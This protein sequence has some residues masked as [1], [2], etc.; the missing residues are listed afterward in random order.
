MT[1][2]LLVVAGAALLLTVA[3]SPRTRASDA[4]A[5]VAAA[6]ARIRTDDVQDLLYLGE[7]RPLRIRLHVRIDGKPFRQVWN[8]FLAR[9]FAEADVNGDKVLSKEEANRLPEARLLLNLVQGQGFFFGGP[10]GSST[11]PFAQLDANKDGKVTLEEVKAYYRKSGF[12]PLQTQPDPDQGTT[13]LLTDALFKHLDRDGDGKLSEKELK[14]AE[15]TLRPLDINEDERISFEELIPG[16]EYGLGRRFIRPAMGNP[17]QPLALVHRD[18]PAARQVAPLLARYDKDKNGKL[19]RTEIGLDEATFAALD[20]NKDGGL[21]A[22]E[23]ARWL[24]QP[25]DLELLVPLG[26]PRT[27]GKSASGADENAPVVVFNPSGRAMPVASSL[28]KKGETALALTSGTTL[29]EFHKEHGSQGNYRRLREFYLEQFRGALRGGKKHLD[30]KDAAR[31]QFFK[32]LFPLLDR[33]GDGKVTEEEVNAFLEL[34]AKGAGC[35]AAVILSQRGPCLFELLDTNQDKQLGLRELRGAWKSV[36]A[37]DANKD[38]ALAKGEL[39]QLLQVTLCA[40]S[41]RRV[42][43]IFGGEEDMKP[44]GKERAAGPLWFRKAD[45]NGDGDVSRREWLGSEE[46]FRRIDTDGDGLISLEEAIKAD[47]WYRK[48]LQTGK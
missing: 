4:D 36:A 18:D 31:S 24:A 16:F 48:K 40:G 37:W 41:P 21:D 44:A 26:R 1:R 17:A 15:E 32:G 14:E 5:L 27:P 9:L 8:D 19:S 23:L 3:A 34:P 29:V 28:R 33:N 11:A 20:T 35:F 13:Q 43:F 39:P 12:A 38:G 47:E 45:V 42:G 30:K 7:K 2:R 46:D 6:L 25:A 10:E 22:K